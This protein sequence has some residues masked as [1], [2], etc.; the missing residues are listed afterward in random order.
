MPGAA[1]VL[2]VA[3]ACS[4][5]GHVDVDLSGVDVDEDSIALVADASRRP[6]VT[7]SYAMARSS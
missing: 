3:A 2:L 5:D 6:A 7:P 4:S 1:V